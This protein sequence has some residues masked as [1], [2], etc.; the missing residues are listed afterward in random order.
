MPAS[1]L[2]MSSVRPSAALGS[3][4]RRA[5]VFFEPPPPEMGTG[6]T[7]AKPKKKSPPEETTKK[8]LNHLWTE[9]TEFAIFFHLI[10]CVRDTLFFSHHHHHIGH[11]SSNKLGAKGPPPPGIWIN[12]SRPS[13][14]YQNLGNAILASFP[15]RGPRKTKRRPG[16]GKFAPRGVSKKKITSPLL[17]R[18]LIF[19]LPP[20]TR[21]LHS[22]PIYLP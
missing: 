4:S 14:I 3:F 15:L 2:F 12:L 18:A 16:H 11:S 13:S 1:Q 22:L 17:I 8:D 6:D 7:R 21:V 19:N 20:Q 5:P 10:L 9:E